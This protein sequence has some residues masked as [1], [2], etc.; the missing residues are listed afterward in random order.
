MIFNKHRPQLSAQNEKNLIS[1]A[2][3][4]QANKVHVVKY[5][6]PFWFCHL[7][8][9]KHIL[10]NTRRSSCSESHKGDLWELGSQR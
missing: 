9:M 7:Q 6:K 8:L 5:F 1:T 3:L 10:S 4:P 2:M